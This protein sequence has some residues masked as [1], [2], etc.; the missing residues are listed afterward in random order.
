M[1]DAHEAFE[2]DKTKMKMLVPLDMNGKQLMNVNL[3]LNLKF[4]DIF[5]I[6]KCETRYSSDR[7]YLFLVRKDNNNVF[8]IFD[9]IYVNSI[10]FHNKQPFDKNA[11]I[12][13]NGRRLN[14]YVIKLSSLVV[15]TGLVRNLTPWLEFGSGLGSVEFYN[16]I[17]NVRAPFDVDVIVSYM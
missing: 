16:L 2:I 10:T 17:N 13:F 3:N 15:D 5:K 9:S 14:I 11:I 8:Q 1:Y 7:S 12:R 6:I 4:G